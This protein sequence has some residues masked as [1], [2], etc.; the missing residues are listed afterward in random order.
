MNTVSLRLVTF[1]M[2]LSL[3]SPYFY[4]VYH[5]FDIRVAAELPQCMSKLEPGSRVSEMEATETQL[6]FPTTNLVPLFAPPMS[7]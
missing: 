6:M 3:L 1:F 4:E 2:Y 5:L 7:F